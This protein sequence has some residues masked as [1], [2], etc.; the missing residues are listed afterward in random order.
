[1][2]N[3]EFMKYKLILLLV[4]AVLIQGCS[5][6]DI[7]DSGNKKEIGFNLST[8]KSQKS[9]QARAGETELADITDFRVSAHLK[10][11][12]TDPFT[13][14]FMYGV[15]VVK[16]APDTWAYSPIKYRPDAGGVDFY[17]Y[18]PANSLSATNFLET[19]TA[20]EVSYIVSSAA[21]LQEDFLIAK[22]LST[23]AAPDWTNPWEGSGAVPLE[24]H[25]AL[26][27]IE[28][29]GRCELPGLRFIVKSITLTNLKPKGD[30]NLNTQTWSNISGTETNYPVSIPEPILF[31]YDTALMAASPDEYEVITDHV[32]GTETAMMLLPQTIVAGSPDAKTT[33][34]GKSHIAVTFAV[35]DWED[36][37]LYGKFEVDS[38]GDIV[39]DANGVPVATEYA[40]VY[41]PLELNAVPALNLIEPGKRYIFQLKFNS[42]EP[43]VFDSMTVEDWDLITPAFDIE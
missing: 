16:T 26:S 43:I 21:D 11:V 36:L 40:T 29:Q 18:S 20:P 31:E 37:A 24:F 13:P 2:K 32:A 25:H 15:R 39:L 41:I 5:N 12:D 4:A 1:M 28:F 7:I 8:K 33:E 3:N 35:L 6:D 14:N 38:F 42:L 19:A 30:I 10:A 17:A 22:S 23:Y 9:L 34:N 27:Q